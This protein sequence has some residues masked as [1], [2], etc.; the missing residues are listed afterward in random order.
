MLNNPF[1]EF[2]AHL[3]KLAYLKHALAVLSWDEEVNMPPYN[4]HPCKGCGLTIK[5]GLQIKRIMVRVRGAPLIKFYVACLCE[6]R[7]SIAYDK[8]EE[9][10]QAWNEINEP[11]T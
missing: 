1:Q 2:K 6:N 9:A 10:A 7:D 3:L 8:M 4:L 5:D 11:S